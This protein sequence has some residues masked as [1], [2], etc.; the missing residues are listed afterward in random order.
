VKKRRLAS[1]CPT[2]GKIGHRT[3]RLA[4]IHAHDF[5]RHHVTYEEVAPLFAYLCRCGKWHLTKSPEGAHE[6]VPVLSIPKELQ[7]WARTKVVPE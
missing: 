1:S 2:P 5:A 4:E 3:L 6:T 7:E